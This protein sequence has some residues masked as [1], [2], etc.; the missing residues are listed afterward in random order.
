MDNGKFQ[1]RS[2]RATRWASAAAL[3]L[4]FL[5]LAPGTGNAAAATPR[6]AAAGHGV[7][8]VLAPVVTHEPDAYELLGV[9]CSSVR[10]CVAVGYGDGT[11]FHGG[12]AVPVTKGVAGK[13][14]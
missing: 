9:S 11:G 4:T 12:V 10:H 5:T 2:V 1:S 6:A 14:V 8:R 7:P 13:P 3:F